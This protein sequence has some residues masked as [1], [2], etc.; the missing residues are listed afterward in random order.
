MNDPKPK[1]EEQTSEP[2]IENK[3]FPDC[4]GCIE[5]QP[6]QM[7]HVGPGGCLEDAYKL[8]ENYE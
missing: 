8:L 2:V 5:Q 4:R 6:N 3:H 1:I 7:A